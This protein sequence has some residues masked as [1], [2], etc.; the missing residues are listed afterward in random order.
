M[1]TV[2]KK[3]PQRK[4]LFMGKLPS[5][6]KEYFF[7]GINE[8]VDVDVFILTG[9]EKKL[10]SMWNEYKDALLS[11]FVSE[12]PGTR[13]FFWWE[14]DAPRWFNDPFQGCSWHGTFSIPRH[15]LDS[16]LEIKQ[17]WDFGLNVKPRFECGIPEDFYY[18]DEKIGYHSSA[19][20]DELKKVFYESQAT[21]LKRHNLF[22]PG[23]AERLTDSD[24]KPQSAF[25]IL[26]IEE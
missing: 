4:K 21:Y 20:A 22:Y 25:E 6:V 9:D 19:D 7:F 24:Y 15:R 26:G 18:F 14:V 23:E 3:K 10:L 2:K 13:P 12:Y 16:N 8:E 11:E 17:P 1:G 5:A